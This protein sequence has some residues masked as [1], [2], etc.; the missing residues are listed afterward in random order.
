MASLF[1]NDDYIIVPAYCPAS[2]AAIQLNVPVAIRF[3][4]CPVIL[5][6][7]CIFATEK[8]LAISPKCILEKLNPVSYEK[9]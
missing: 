1:I 5:L 9:T 8:L 7:T 6:N 2:H 3:T 4:M